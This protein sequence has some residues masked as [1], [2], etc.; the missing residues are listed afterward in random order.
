MPLISSAPLQNSVSSSA[1]SSTETRCSVLGALVVVLECSLLLKCKAEGRWQLQVV[2]LEKH[3]SLDQKVQSQA[4]PFEHMN[5]RLRLPKGQQ[6]RI[7][8]LRLWD[9]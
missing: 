2:Q 4:L 5:R 8:S 6:Q 1:L 7:G 9:W 3:L